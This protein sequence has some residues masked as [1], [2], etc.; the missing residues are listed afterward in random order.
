MKTDKERLIEIVDSFTK[1]LQE[2]HP[3]ISDFAGVT[4]KI[5][6]E[7]VDEAQEKRAARLL[8]DKEMLVE[9]ARDLKLRVRE[10]ER[11]QVRDFDLNNDRIHIV[12]M[13][14][15]ERY[16][17]MPDEVSERIRNYITAQNLGKDDQLFTLRESRIHEILLQKGLLRHMEVYEKLKAKECGK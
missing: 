10:Y 11:L 4:K 7:Y 5:T 13:G 14:G 6:A 1:W 3:E 2:K 16:V 12:S 9:I 15:K 8:A 17:Y